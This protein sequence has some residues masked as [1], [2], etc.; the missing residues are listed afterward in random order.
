MALVRQ[1]DRCGKTFDHK[2][3]YPNMYVIGKLQDG[4]DYSFYYNENNVKTLCSDCMESL[5]NWF[6]TPGMQ[7]ES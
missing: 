6:D 1:C 3:K 7:K 4:K 2:T 5:K